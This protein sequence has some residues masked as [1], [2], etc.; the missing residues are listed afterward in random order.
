MRINSTRELEEN[1]LPHILNWLGL[2]E[3]QLPRPGVAGNYEHLL[4]VRAS[5][6][7]APAA[8]PG[9]GGGGTT[10]TCCKLGQSLGDSGLNVQ[11]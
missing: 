8:P 11:A 10:S 9:G 5:A 1:A 3:D 7:G 4:Q 2:R 6:W